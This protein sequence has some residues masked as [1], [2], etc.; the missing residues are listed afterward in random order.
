MREKRDNPDVDKLRV[1]C[2]LLIRKLKTLAEGGDARPLLQIANLAA[3]EWMEIFK[4]R[5][6][7]A[8]MAL[9]N[10]TSFPVKLPAANSRRKTLLAKVVPAMAEACGSKSDFHLGKGKQPD[11]EGIVN[12]T[13]M[14]YYHEVRSVRGK[15]AL[16]EKLVQDGADIGSDKKLKPIKPRDE[17]L[18]KAF[19]L[20][21]SI[22]T[23]ASARKWFAV[24]WEL[25]RFDSNGQPH[26]Y[27]AAIGSSAPTAKTFLKN[28]FFRKFKFESKCTR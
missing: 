7:S 10:V 23:A 1:Q 18:A 21:K 6:R 15:R 22:K 4:K 13:L 25:W 17:I 27:F 28:T 26:T 8:K 5:R 3:F 24:I 19:L 20:P 2:E 9:A 12:E 11:F 14:G 16:L